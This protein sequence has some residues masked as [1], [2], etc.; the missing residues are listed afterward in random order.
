M[1]DFPMLIDGRLVAAQRQF[2]VINPADESVVGRAPNASDHD[3][4]QAVAAAERAFAS[5]RHT[6]TEQRGAVLTAIADVIDKHADELI[7]LLVAEQ[8][9]PRAQAQREVL[10]QAAARLRVRATQELKPEVIRDDAKARVEIHYRP[11]GVAAAIVPWNYPFGIAAGKLATALMAGCTL[12]LKPSPFTPLATLRLGALI[13]DVVPP[14]VVNIVCGDDSFG[15]KV[16][17]HPGIKKISFTGSIATG[18]KVMQSAAGDLKRITLELGGNDAAIL[19]DDVDL[20]KAAVPLFMGA[21]VNA[22]QT[23]VAIKRVYAPD[24]IYEDV[25]QA[26]ATLAK[27]AKVGPGSDPESTIGPIQNRLQY[28]RVLAVLESVKSGEGRIVAGGEALPGKGYFIAPTIVADVKEGC[29]LVDE[30]TFGPILPVIRYS[31]VDDAIRRANATLYGLGGSVWSENL[32]RAAEVARQLDTGTAWV[33]QHPAL[34][35]DVP[36]AGAKHSGIGVESGVYGLREFSQ[37]HVV[38]IR[39]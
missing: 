24:P 21:F 26:L 4:D 12:V 1:S 9:K 7:D 27:R 31:D 16:T 22:G 37:L 29:R 36:F 15:P 2:D 6:G 23:C 14:G 8:G 25:V 5:W 28:E 35:P 30:E 34:S 32:E 33:N 13:K 20:E 11:L 17:A 10:Q 18:K 39:K 3:L 38:N 19:L